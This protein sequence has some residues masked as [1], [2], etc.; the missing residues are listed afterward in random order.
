M[1]IKQFKYS[2]DNLGYLVYSTT[3]GIAID[4][5]AVEET[6]VYAQNKNITIKYITNTHSHNDHTSGNKKILEKTKAIF[7]DCDSIKSDQDIHLDH[8]IL[9][10]FHTPGHTYDSV[11]F[12]AEDLLITGD[13]LFNGTIGNCFSGDL[14]AFFHSLKRLTSFPKSTKIFSGHDYV[15]ESL[16]IAQDI[17]KDNFFIRNYLKKYNP[18]LV[19]ST[20][21]DELKVNPFLRFNA[22][23][24]IKDLQQKKMPSNTEMLRFKSIMEIY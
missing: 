24:I 20:L 18:E 16:Q 5:G 2:T 21:E 15:L 6:I 19:V 13:T 22:S 12:H 8:E 23:G 17:E 10:V 14:D 11:T 9:K 4:A 3:E 7:I 1:H